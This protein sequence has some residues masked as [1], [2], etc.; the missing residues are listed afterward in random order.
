MTGK[1]KKLNRLKRLAKFVLI[2]V[3][4]FALIFSVFQF[5]HIRFNSTESMPIGFYQIQKATTLKSGDYVLVC[6]PD[7]I[8]QEGHERGYLKKGIGCTNGAEPLLKE[9]IAVPGDNVFLTSNEMIVNG[10]GYQAPLFK[11]DRQGRATV[12]VQRG[13]YDHTSLYWLY[14][15]HDQTYSWDSRYYGGV[16][17]ENIMGIARPLFITQH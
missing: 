12:Y 8:A 15:E 13:S 9:L 4:G 14:G 10:V 7:P 2:V 3:L 17:R 16:G 1:N 5:G 11:I 6:L